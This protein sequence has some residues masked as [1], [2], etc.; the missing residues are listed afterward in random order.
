MFTNKHVI[1]A[2]IVAPILA[3]LAWFAV[4]QL[5]G[6]QPHVAEP[7]QSYPLVE[8]SN[9]RYESGACDLENEDFRL[10]LTLQDGVTGPE[11]LLTSSHTLEG[12]VL[13][14]GAADAEAQPAPMRA[15]DGQGLQ[16]RIVLGEKPTPDQ[17]IRLVARAAGSSYFAEASTT[18]L[19]P[20]K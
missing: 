19:Q 16:W 9:C 7:G 12:V 14:V 8:K 2:M 13:S 11:F 6:E 10:R 3:V 1:I 18:F 5:T 4:G 20:S 17:R 15:S